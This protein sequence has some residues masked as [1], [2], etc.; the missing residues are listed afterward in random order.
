QSLPQAVTLTPTKLGHYSFDLKVVAVPLGKD[1]AYGR[2]V[3]QLQRQR[4]RHLKLAADKITGSITTKKPGILTS[5]IPYSSGWQVK[6]NGQKQPVLRT[7]TAFLGVKLGRGTHHVT[8][9]Y[10]LPGIKLG[11]T[12]SLAG[13]A[14]LA[15]GL[16]TTWLTRPRRQH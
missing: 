11:S 15:L 12:L 13:L 5:T 7:N 14:L 3:K 1:S 2:Q 6:V 16:L 8:F 10:H 9:S 4:L